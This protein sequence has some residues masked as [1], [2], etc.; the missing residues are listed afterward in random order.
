MMIT[1]TC[2]CA[3]VDNGGPSAGG[4]FGE[5]GYAYFLGAAAFSKAC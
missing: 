4:F 2:R 5:S 1:P 3:A